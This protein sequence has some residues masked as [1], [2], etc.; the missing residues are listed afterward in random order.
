MCIL[1]IRQQN[2]TFFKR[3]TEKETPQEGH[4]LVGAAT[5]GRSVHRASPAR[6]GK[7]PGAGRSPESPAPIP[8]RRPA[9]RTGRIHVLGFT[10]PGLWASHGPP[11]PPPPGPGQS[12]TFP[13]A[14]QPQSGSSFHEVSTLCRPRTPIFRVNYTAPNHNRSR[15]GQASSQGSGRAAPLALQAQR[16]SAWPLPVTAA[17][18]PSFQDPAPRSSRPTEGCPWGN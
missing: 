16:L 1:I 5:R 3:E 7:P 11:Q 17:W 15:R 2:K 9:S 14:Q 18:A 4:V 13:P 8:A 10:P 12:Q 6:A